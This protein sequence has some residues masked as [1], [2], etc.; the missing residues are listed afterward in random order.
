[1]GHW[2]FGEG[3]GWKGGEMATRRALGLDGAPGQVMVLFALVITVLIGFVALAI[4]ATYLMSER[5]AAQNA[6]DAAAM[7]V[8]KALA[9]NLD[10][11]GSLVTQADA[12][13]IAERFAALNGF[14]DD[15]ATTIVEPPILKPQPPYHPRQVTVTVTR[16]L[17]PFFLRAL[18]TG[19]WS[20]SA[21]A[22][23]TVINTGE[24][25]GL[26]AL[27]RDGD[28]VVFGGLSAGGSQSSSCTKVTC[29]TII[30]EDPSQACGSVGSNTDI[31]F[32]GN[33]QGSVDGNLEAAGNIVKQPEGTF[34]VN[35][36]A[37]GSMGGV[38]DP[39]WGTPSPLAMGAC[40]GDPDIAGW[41]DATNT[42]T[43]H[44]G[45]YTQANKG[46]ALAKLNSASRIIFERGIY[47]F[48]G[49]SFD[50]PNK[51]KVI[52]GGAGVLLYFSGG[53]T[54][55]VASNTIETLT[56]RDAKAAGTS[57]NQTGDAARWDE[58]A[59][60][61]DNANAS[62]ACNS[63]NVLKVSG[64]GTWTIEGT[65]YAPC[66]SIQFNGNKSTATLSGMLIGYEVKLQ[67]SIDLK[68]TVPP[69]DEL[70][71]PMVYLTR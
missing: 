40:G 22:T 11:S 68:I 60:W 20:V 41:D 12:E 5:R 4:D 19:P 15:G 9:R 43:L 49:V 61:I 48:D 30:C 13:G 7:A 36:F 35:G 27:G 31:T 55:S 33:T 67:G 18:Y 21:T 16:Q 29:I 1:M 57:W 37:A 46:T 42:L 17:Q 45:H 10:S 8:G 56:I 28:G 70:K 14:S 54:F 65:I 63:V 6:A 47:C 32:N 2:R 38:T 59:I 24:H 26:L 51:V 71:P 23:A 44:P 50:P 3:Q 39:L 52:D 69:S 64:T 34:K 62:G 25:F 53:G 66:T 58:I